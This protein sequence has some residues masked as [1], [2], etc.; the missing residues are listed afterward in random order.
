MNERQTGDGVVDEIAYTFG[1]CDELDPLRL[2]LPLLRAGLA[3]PAVQSACELGFGYG[4]SVNIH[5]AG[6]GASWYG[7]DFNA[8]HAGFAQSLAREAGSRAV[9]SGERFADFCRREDLPSST[10]SACTASGAGCP[11]R[12]APGS[13]ASCT[14]SSRAACST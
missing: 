1:Y 6:S 9:L 14:A 13:P 8:A 5:A 12:T 4:V 10:S 7:T 11:T 2:A 3:A